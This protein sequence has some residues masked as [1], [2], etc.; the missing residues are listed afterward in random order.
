MPNYSRKELLKTTSTMN[1]LRNM[2]YHLIKYLSNTGKQSQY[3]KKSLRKMGQNIGKTESPLFN[4]DNQHLDKLI[5]TMY[6]EILG[7]KVTVT[8]KIDSKVY[9]IESKK[10]CVCKYH[11]KDITVAPCE[12]IHSMVSELLIKYGFIVEE[13]IVEES[14]ALGSLSC[15]HS[16][17]FKN[18]KKGD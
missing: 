2:L 1:Q 11:R 4:F 9:V 12:I 13:S 15:V 16:Y 7:S 3:I 5:K 6:D 8:N 10:C 18:L 17:K 14:I